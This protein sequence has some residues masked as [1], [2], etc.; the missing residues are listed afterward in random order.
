[1]QV[2]SIS[3]CG[4]LILNMHSLNNEGGEGNQIMT[5]Q[6][7]IID[8]LGQFS[9]VNA[10][11]GD[12]L[13]HIQSE[14]FW[15]I[16]VKE[17]L[18]L[19]ESCRLFSP[20]RI[21]E[22]EKFTDSFTKDTPDSIVLDKVIQD[23]CL[24]EVEGILITNNNKNVPRKS[25]IEF[26]WLI[27]LPESTRTENYFHVKLVSDSGTK[28]SGEGAN[29][30]QNIFHRP[31]N[32][33][34]YALVSNYDIGRVGYNDISKKYVIS[35]DD[36]RK[37]VNALLQSILYTFIQPNGAMRNT[38]NPHIVNFSGIITIS[39]GNVPAP[40]VSPINSAY[41][42]EVVAIANNL[43]KIVPDSIS[44]FEF[45]SMSSFSEKFA[46]IINEA[47]PYKLKEC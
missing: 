21:T 25:C 6:V 5:R 46:Q 15:S 10:V 28:K 23:S 34:I 14:H 30:G 4:R 27:G 35:D 22:D 8:E 40:T 19:S 7:T 42:T 1:M 13:K 33:G 39:S 12:M 43:N 9:T 26:G 17:D 16:A 3:I 24:S 44:V 11:S 2:S 18:P 36:R 38:Q 47:D 45:E 37:R 31:A 41:N 20:N 32:S 29:L